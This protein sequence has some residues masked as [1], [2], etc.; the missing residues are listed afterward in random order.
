LTANVHFNK[1]LADQS[2]SA[3][4]DES[5]VMLQSTI[6]EQ[7]TDGRDGNETGGLSDVILAIA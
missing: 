1:C 5:S 7:T 6:G 3:T 4:H 2:S